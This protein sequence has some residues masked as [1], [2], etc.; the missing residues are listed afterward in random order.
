MQFDIVFAGS[1]SNQLK[2]DFVAMN[3]N[4]IVDSALAS[5]NGGWS[6]ST[7]SWRPSRTD[8]SP[9]PAPAAILL[10]MLGLGLVGWVKRRIA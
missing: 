3:G 2:F 10:G 9:V 4:T 7:T 6:F 1:S 8:L 5:W